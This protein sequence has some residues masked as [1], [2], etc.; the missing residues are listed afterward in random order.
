LADGRRSIPREAPHDGDH[1]GGGYGRI[2]EVVRGKTGH[3]RQMAHRRLAAIGLP[4]GVGDEADR[5][6]ERQSRRDG[7]K[8][9][10][11][12]RQQILQP[13]QRIEHPKAACRECEHRQRI[14]KPV[15]LDRRVNPREAVEAPLHW[16]KHGRQDSPL[17]FENFGNEMP[18][19]AGDT[20]YKGQHQDNLQPATDG[21]GTPFRRR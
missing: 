5:R 3:L 4:I 16:P 11:V 13:L 8:S 21:Q 20:D 2:E 15:L 18:E 9:L 14:G 6:I 1:Q 7:V 17:S 10:R 12:A 19:R